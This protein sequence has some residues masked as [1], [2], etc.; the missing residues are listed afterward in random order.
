MNGGLDFLCKLSIFDES[1]QTCPKYTKKEVFY[2][3]AKHLDTLQGSSHVCYLFLG[4]FGQKA[5]P[6]RSWNSVICCISRE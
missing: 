6:F 4:G 3:D 2:C 1:S 5:W